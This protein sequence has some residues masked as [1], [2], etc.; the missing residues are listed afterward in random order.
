[1][2]EQLRRAETILR[3]RFF[4]RDFLWPGVIFACAFIARLILLHQGPKP[5]GD[6]RFYIRTGQIFVYLLSQGNFLD[7]RW[8]YEP[9]LFPPVGCYFFGIALWCAG[10]QVSLDPVTGLPPLP[11]GSPSVFY[12]ARLVN[13]ILSSA[14]CVSIFY[15]GRLLKSVR[16]GLIA[17]LIWAFDPFSMDLS[18]LALLE[19]SVMFFLI[20]SMLAFFRGAKT[21][22]T[23]WSI[24]SGVLFGLAVG[25]KL[26]GLLEFFI[27]GVLILFLCF[28]HRFFKTKVSF[29]PSIHVFLY[30]LSICS[31]VGIITFIISWPFLWPNPILRLSVFFSTPELMERVA[32][33]PPDP[34]W[35]FSL[36]TG[37]TAPEL[38]L[39][40]W[41][42]IIA[43][44]RMF[45]GKL[46][47]FES[48]AISWFVTTLTF[49]TFFMTSHHGWYTFYVTPAISFL[50]SAGILDITER[51]GIWSKVMKLIPI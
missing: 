39:A 18:R 43:S 25:S 1:M 15:L 37:C 11:Y 23:K 4:L 31:V 22:N 26:F 20:L 49:I 33:G 9:L 50:A 14:T 13:V 8:R 27:L 5:L 24:I 17:A 30:Y 21:L 36:L 40:I 28:K 19:S 35:F 38:I 34:F 47:F 29:M 44:S 12:Y 16:A 10:Y 51:F 6:E 45:N 2:R 3:F 41:G 7:P 48:L 32:L 42:L 46:N